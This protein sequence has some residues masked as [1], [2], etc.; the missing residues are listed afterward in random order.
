MSGFVRTAELLTRDGLKAY[1]GAGC[2]DIPILS[3]HHCRRHAP[4][5][6]EDD[7][8]GTYAASAQ[9]YTSPAIVVPKPVPAGAIVVAANAGSDYLFVPDGNT[10]TVKAAVAEPAEPACNSARSS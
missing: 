2:R 9:K 1:D 10:D 5:A 3:G 6:A 7:E 8:D 4:S